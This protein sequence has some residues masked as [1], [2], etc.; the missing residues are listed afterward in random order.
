MLKIFNAISFVISQ[1]V[2]LVGATK[3]RKFQ[4]KKLI[5]NKE[6]NFCF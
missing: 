3:S 5:T 4:A 2:S 6:N 1:F